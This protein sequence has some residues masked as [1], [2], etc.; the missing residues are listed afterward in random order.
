MNVKYFACFMAVLPLLI[1]PSCPPPPKLPGITLDPPSLVFPPQLIDPTGTVNN[2]QTV[3]ITSS[4]S[5][6]L[7]ISDITAS[8][9]FNQSNNCPT[10]MTAHTSCTMQVTFGPNAVG[11]VN[12]AVTI[13]SNALNRRI[14]VVGL[15]G[16]GLP[17]IS[18]R[19]ASLDFG[20]IAVGISSSAQSITLTNNLGTTLT[21]S[22]L[23]VSGGYT[24]T[25]NCG[26]VSA[27]QSCQ[28]N[29]KFS[30]SLAG[31]IA[32]ALSVTSDASP[33][34]QPVGLSGTGTGTVTSAL[35]LSP[36]LLNFGNHEAGS[37]SSAKTVTVTNTG[38]STLNVTSVNV[39]SG[40][41]IG[42]DSCSG[43]SLSS[44]DTCSISVKFSP[45]ADLATVD[46]PGALTII[47][48]DP[49]NA[50]VVGL[51]GTAVAPI[52]A[53]PPALDFGT[54]ATDPRGTPLTSPPSLN[55]TLLNNHGASEDISIASSGHYDLSNNCPPTLTSG[56]H[57]SANV[58]F[59]SAYTGGTNLGAVTVTSSSGGFLSPTTVNLSAC[60]TAVSFWPPSFD[61]GKLAP[62]ASSQPATVT[63][64]NGSGQDLNFSSS[65][66]VTGANSSDFA[67]SDNNCTSPLSSG[68]TCTLDVIDTPAASGARGAAL[69]LAD[70]GDCSPQQVSLKSGSAT[71]PFTIYLSLNDA[72]ASGEIVSTP[73]GIDCSSGNCSGKF[74]A[75]TKVT[76]EGSPASA[77]QIAWSG[78]CSGS[79]SCSFTM[80]SDKQVAATLNRNP[81]LIVTITGTGGG[82]VT[83]N[84][85]GINCSSPVT[86]DTNCVADFPPG[87]NVT[88]TAKTGTDSRFDGWSGGGCS[89]TG[90]CSFV[91]SSD[92]T[93]TATFTSTAPDFALSASPLN[94]PS[95]A[96]GKSATSGVTVSSANGFNSAVNLTCSV[97]PIMNL[98][99]TCALSP[100]SV[101]PAANGSGTATLTV[102]TTAPS[103]AEKSSAS[104]SFFFAFWMLMTGIA[105]LGA[106]KCKALS[107][108]RVAW[109]FG[110]GA[111]LVAV[112]LESACGGSSPIKPPPHGGTQAGVYAVVITGTAGTASH[113]ASTNLTVD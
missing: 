97:T 11:A 80:D 88:L 105:W 27:G 50:Q 87:Q 29:V 59:S 18:F 60:A 14:A 39:S 28:I 37:T 106:P 20:S 101:T 55:L 95:V 111:L 65:P 99:P 24:Q 76:L 47:D 48:T 31:A 23:G 64:T 35:S 22:H 69:T 7:S 8:G 15:S 84:P 21:I 75:G 102:S 40:Y 81:E 96:P 112:A 86:G 77:F 100:S 6:T 54:V 2:S 63:V 43:S 9:Q 19:P 113:S 58:A 62:G 56:A 49:T 70:D 42:T 25:N 71:G 73:A 34:A 5:G 36:A 107:G 26:S 83:S 68:N 94:P 104:R 13:T 108:R 57:C 30:P 12:G 74:P 98:A 41:Q 89:G 79:S 93:I 17:P 67:I 51:A 16:T 46:Y 91:S 1:S 72:T 52:S 103:V 61:F 45:A 90:T 53:A 82:T 33:D 85:G 3:T 110:G 44:A 92:Q 78:A 32:G 4:G 109:I 66:S 38:S 10:S